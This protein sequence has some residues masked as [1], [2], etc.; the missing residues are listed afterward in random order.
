MQLCKKAWCDVISTRVAAAEAAFQKSMKNSKTFHFFQVDTIPWKLATSST[1]DITSWESLAG[2]TSLPYGCA[3]TWSK[4]SYLRKE[5]WKKKL[6]F[7]SSFFFFQWQEVC[8]PQ[9]GQECCALHWNSSRWDQTAQM[10]KYFKRA[11][12]YARGS[13]GPLAVHFHTL[14]V[15]YMQM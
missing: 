3:G 13:N 9:S 12:F 15:L 8:R 4:S 1:I 2:A 14:F 5:A 10:R 7:S 6:I 11:I